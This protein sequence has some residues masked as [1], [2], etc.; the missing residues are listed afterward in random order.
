[1]KKDLPENLP[2]GAW[3]KMREAIRQSPD[4]LEFRAGDVAQSK[5]P[6]AIFKF[7]RD[8]FITRPD[9]Y[10]GGSDIHFRDRVNWGTPGLLRSGIGTP[11]EKAELLQS[12]FTQADFKARILEG[13]MDIEAIGFERLFFKHQAPKF[14]PQ[15][16]IAPIGEWKSL[17]P[18]PDL[19]QFQ[20]IDFEALGESS[21]ITEI[22]NA[23]GDK[24]A[25][26]APDWPHFL[27]NT[28]IVSVEIEGKEQ[29]AN[30]HILDL[31]FGEHG[32]K[33]PPRIAS[34]QKPIATPEVKVKLSASTTSKPHDRFPLVDGSWKA[35]DLV[36]RQLKI[37]FMPTEEA[38]EVL[39]MR[40]G[41]LKSFIPVL[42][43]Q[44][45]NLDE[46]EVKK[47]SFAG[48]LITI[49][50]DQ[51][52]SEIDQILINNKPIAINNGSPE[53]IEKVST[54][55]V[56]AE[57]GNWPEVK[58]R[59][60]V[61]DEQGQTVPDL[62]GS[63]FHVAENDRAVPCQLIRNTPQP[64][65]ILFVFDYSG[66]MKPEFRGK[67]LAPLVRTICTS[68]QE[69]YGDVQI[70]LSVIS[71]DTT[72]LRPFTPWLDDVDEAENHILKYNPGGLQT[73][74]YWTALAEA[75]NKDANMVVMFTDADGTEEGTLQQHTSVTG[76]C[77]AVI[78]GVRSEKTREDHLAALAA[79][80]GG[81]HTMAEDHAT[82]TEAVL[83][84]LQQEHNWPY[85]FSYS[86]PVN[87]SNE[88]IK[89][90]LETNDEKHR[91]ETTYTADSEPKG[92]R[93]FAGLYLE[94]SIGGQQDSRT[95]AGLTPWKSKQNPVTETHAK[96]TR[97]A[98][99]GEFQISFEGEAPTAS[100]MLDN[101]L[102]SLLS[103]EPLLTSLPGGTEARMIA[104][105]E[106]GAIRLP[107]Q[108]SALNSAL[109]PTLTKN[110]FTYQEGWRVILFSSVPAD[111]GQIEDRS[112]VL[113]F[114]NWRTISKDPSLA[115]ETTLA[116][117]LRLS[118]AET[119]NF[120]ISTGS[121]LRGKKLQAL[122]PSAFSSKHLALKDES[123]KMSWLK[124]VQSREP[125]AKHEL[126]LVPDD[127]QI[128]AY[129]AL[130]TETGSILGFLRNGTGGG[131]TS[132]TERYFNSIDSGLQAFDKVMSKLNL[133]SPA[134]AVWVQLERIKV[135]KV[136]LATMLLLTM[137][138]S[139]DIGD[140]EDQLRG[141]IRDWARDLA[142]EQA[143]KFIGPIGDFNNLRDWYEMATGIGGFI[144]P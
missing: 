20:P 28:S 31:P 6:E 57:A 72:G 51:I 118:L 102:G 2:F 47:M 112:D 73:S 16:A 37:N 30:P 45:G 44:A 98:L 48:D 53:N 71:Y 115:G 60:R 7:V 92:S 39:R 46:E 35:A 117:S 127:S 70:Q 91:A 33:I 55:E 11:R 75:T 40:L 123:L 41:D 135:A 10:R 114:T 142:L 62:P 137:D 1:M 130:N 29:H 133:V 43:V 134:F 3:K 81:S 42:S 26:P 18:N 101:V 122:N 111:D 5:N 100:A 17:L 65:R 21:L 141:E 66:S 58:L 95:L 23:V 79:A 59:A 8:N 13:E 113:S 82:A 67:G 90:F 110:T 12:L 14:A 107:A 131:E 96:E 93:S 116:H 15:E 68:A 89:V 119:A 105:M 106:K 25:A 99:F 54:L 69:K 103:L 132:D 9:R 136:K 124:A 143:G 108:W 49:R 97:N 19:P 50:G 94:I 128:D 120:E 129:W 83:K 84:R 126:A 144:A 138:G 109:G 125:L 61:L 56:E 104:A 121:I 52:K 63:S 85:L 24:L 78:I 87:E 22:K 77:P 27:R 86:S 140:F 139:I 38:P 74:N 80:S 64:P 4:H 34:Q 88:P 36:G 76:G 32:L